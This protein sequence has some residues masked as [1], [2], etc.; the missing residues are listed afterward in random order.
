MKHYI[1]VKFTE[2]FD[3]LSLLDEIGGIFN[4]T[5][6]ISGI[7]AVNIRKSNSDR[8]NRYDIMIEIDMDARAL[9]DYDISAPH[10]EW[11]DRFGEYIEKKAIFDCE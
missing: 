1:I 7:N 6:E 5:L 2:G 10:K 11:K 8:S 4:R 3:Y 9:A